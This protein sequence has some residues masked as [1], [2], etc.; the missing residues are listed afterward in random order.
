METVADIRRLAEASRGL[1]GNMT[2]GIIPTIGPYLL[3][4]LL[5]AV[6]QAFPTLRLAIR[7]SRTSTLSQELLAGRLDM[8]I[9]A[10]PVASGEFATAPIATDRF[11]LAT[12]KGK[13]VPRKR[14]R[15]LEFIASEHLLLLEEGNCL[16]DQALRHCDA[17]GVRYGEIYGTSNIS[18]LVQ[19]VAHGMGITLVP[20]LCLRQRGLLDEVRLTRFAEPQ[21]HR[22]IALAWRKTSPGAERFAE[23]GALTRQILE[24]RDQRI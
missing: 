17:A 9:V 12:Q 7:E 21:P 3:P 13:P 22:V 8:M 14:E 16:R 1:A 19:M 20:E 23:F 24:R 11:L 5:P 10:L 4:D 2:L 15:L 18:T 6:R